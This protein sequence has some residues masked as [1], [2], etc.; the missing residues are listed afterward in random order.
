MVRSVRRRRRSRDGR[1]RGSGGFY[2][3]PQSY[4]PAYG[5][6]VDRLALLLS[7]TRYPGFSDPIYAEAYVK[8]HGFDILLGK[9]PARIICIPVDADIDEFA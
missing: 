4:L 8:V 2:L 6:V 1:Q 5:C 7:I 3:E 9:H